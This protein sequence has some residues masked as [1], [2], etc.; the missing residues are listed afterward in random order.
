[1]KKLILAMF[2][3]FCIPVLGNAAIIDFEDLTLSSYSITPGI[4]YTDVTFT[5]T[6]A[7]GN[8]SVQGAPGLPLLGNVVIGPN[9][10]NSGE[11]YKAIL[12]ISDIN[13][14]SVDIG[15]FGADA[16]YLVLNA[17]NSSSALIGSANGLLA[18]DI[19]GGLTLSVLT[20][21]DIAYVLFNT[22][23]PYP[24]SVYIDNFT[25]NKNTAVPEPAT[26]L[27]LGLGL[28]GLAA[29]RKKS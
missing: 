19:N 24:G 28:C 16:D 3:M 18:A 4:E 11:M 15:D 5:Y 20:S 10:H 7:T 8:F 9:A 14:V 17:Y 22:T 27:L 23:S 1:M 25:Y 6:G 13:F 21:E 29:M 2:L 26:M 12:N